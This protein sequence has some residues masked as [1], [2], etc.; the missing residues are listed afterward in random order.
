MYNPLMVRKAATATAASVLAGLVSL[1][2][3]GPAR[4]DAPWVYRSIVLPRG[5][6]A[7]DVGLGLG[8]EPEPDNNSITG[9]GMNLEISGSITH[10]LEIGLRTGFRLDDSGQTTRADGYGRP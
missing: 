6:I 5:E 4:A 1:V 10:E 9:F 7:V 3:A 2:W 8:H